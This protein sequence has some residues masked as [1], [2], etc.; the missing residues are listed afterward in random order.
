LVYERLAAD[1]KAAGILALRAGVDVGISLEEA[2]MKPLRE[3]V[4]EGKADIAL[5]DRSVRRILRLKFALGLFEK[6]YV[7]VERAASE[8]YR[9]RHRDLALE[10]ARQSI[11]LLKNGNHLLP[12][13]AN[14]R[15]VAVIGPNADNARN[16]L[17]DYTSRTILQDVVTVL[18]GIRHR[19]GPQADVTY[20]E[21]CNVTGN[22][23]NQIERAREAARKAQVAVVVVGESMKTNGEGYDVASLDLTGM[24]EELIKAVHSTGTPTI[25]VLVNG[26]PLSIRWTAENVPAIVEA[27]LPGEQG[28]HAVAEV[29]FG[30]YNPSGRLP[31]TVPR[32]AGQLPAYYNHKPSKAYWTSRRGYA[33]MKATPL[34]EFGYGLS[35]TSFEYSGLELSPREIPPSG[36]V[37]IRA[38][39]KNTGKRDGHEVVQLYINDVVSSVTRPV[40]ELKGFEKIHLRPGE[41]KT[42]TFTLTPADL[43]LLDEN[44]SPVVEPGRFDIMVGS[45]SEDIRL[46]GNFEVRGR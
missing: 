21:G 37:T 6:P 34:F 29:L 26:R 16:Q 43:A 20:V 7:D 42:V 8:P 18:K 19:L 35:Y 3:S 32:H 14:I 4:Q 13:G 41:T 25:V 5:I 38:Q 1:Q 2:Y 45:S 10:A 44:L 27:W 40:K 9:S 22:E 33:D 28:G 15:S 23:L 36:T 24:Q 31:I 39:V 46:R 11:V 17:G 30:D 12:L